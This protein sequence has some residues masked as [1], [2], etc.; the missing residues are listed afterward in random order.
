MKACVMMNKDDK[1]CGIEELYGTNTLDLNY[2][3]VFTANSGQ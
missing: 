1:K 3:P 2:T